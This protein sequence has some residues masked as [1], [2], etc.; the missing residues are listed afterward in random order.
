MALKE[1]PKERYQD[2][3]RIPKLVPNGTKPS[4]HGRANANF[5]K[6]LPNFL[7]GPTN[8]NSSLTSEPNSSL[9]SEPNRTF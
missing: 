9:T 3:V 4:S 1:I 7:S 6:N 2:F 8:L 5:P